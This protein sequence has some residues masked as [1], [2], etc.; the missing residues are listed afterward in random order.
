MASQ[1]SHNGVFLVYFWCNFGSLEVLRAKKTLF[2]VAI[3]SPFCRHFVAGIRCNFGAIQS[4]F[5]ST[6]CRGFVAGIR[7]IFGSVLVRFGAMFCMRICA[8]FAPTLRPHYV[9]R[10]APIICMKSSK[11]STTTHG[12]RFILWATTGILCPS[13]SICACSKAS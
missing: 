1:I 6:F 3:L 8:H 5:L 4:C 9:V 11:L 13:A 7:C 10:F 12:F 2:F